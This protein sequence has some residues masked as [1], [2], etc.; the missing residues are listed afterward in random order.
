MDNNKISA[1]K[2][3]LLHPSL[4]IKMEVLSTAKQTER[5][6][7]YTIGHVGFRLIYFLI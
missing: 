2:M 7:T 3:V 6:I 1:Q 4:K 5:Q